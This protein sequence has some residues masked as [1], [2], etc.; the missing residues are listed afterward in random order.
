MQDKSVRQKSRR[1]TAI[2]PDRN[3]SLKNLAAR[4]KVV[5]DLPLPHLD[6]TFAAELE[7]VSGTR[8][9]MR[10]VDRQVGIRTVALA[11]WAGAFRQ[12]TIMI[13]NSGRVR[14]GLQL[15]YHWSSPGWEESALTAVVRKC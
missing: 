11:I 1:R 6:S 2:D 15:E 5:N 7:L 13:S 9:Q 8:R 4:D 10:H 12:Q 14:S 3:E